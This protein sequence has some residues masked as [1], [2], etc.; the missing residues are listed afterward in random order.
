MIPES[1]LHRSNTP[2]LV[3]I[4][5]D[6]RR[7]ISLFLFIFYF[8]LFFFLD[9]VYLLRLVTIKVLIRYQGI[10]LYFFPL[11]LTHPIWITYKSENA[12][13]WED[14]YVSHQN[15]FHEYYYYISKNIDLTM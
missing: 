2:S 5:Q 15:V 3:V 14:T 10:Y 13:G 11:P 4:I 7:K 9:Y 8:F 1:R 12:S 6:N